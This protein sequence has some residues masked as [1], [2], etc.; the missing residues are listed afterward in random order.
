MQRKL[1]TSANASFCFRSYTWY[2]QFWSEHR[3]GFIL[4][5]LTSPRH[6]KKHG[7][8]SSNSLQASYKASRKHEQF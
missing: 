5:N 8:N 4:P 3:R 2:L 6:L 1:A 7:Q